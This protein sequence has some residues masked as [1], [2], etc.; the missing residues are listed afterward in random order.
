[1]CKRQFRIKQ[2]QTSLHLVTLPLISQYKLTENIIQLIVGGDFAGDLAE[3]VQ[4]GGGYPTQAD[5]KKR[6]SIWN[7]LALSYNTY[8]DI[9][10]D[11]IS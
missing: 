8:C 11:L 5:H 10:I 1:M 3:V 2:K 7:S 9:F 4:C 6:E